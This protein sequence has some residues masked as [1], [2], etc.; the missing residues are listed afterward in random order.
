[1]SEQLPAPEVVYDPTDPMNRKEQM[2]PRLDPSMVRRIAA[3][4]QE[5][6]VPAGTVLFERGQ[7]GIDFFLVLD[8][9]VEI[10]DVDKY[11]QSN[12]FT[13][14]SSRQFSGEMNMFN[15]RAVM[16]SA[17]VAMDS[18]ILRVHSDDFRRMVAAEADISEIIMRAFILRRVGLIRAGF[19]GVVLVGPGH[20]A[21]TLRLERFLVRNGYPHRLID[22]ESEPE[23]DGFI[24]CFQLAHEQLP[25]VICP[26]RCFL[27]NPTTAELADELGITET[28]DPDF[29]YDVVVA[30][31]GPA[32]LAAAVYAAS[33]GL[34]TLVVEGVAP[35]GQA[36]TS[37][38]IENY[39]G[40]PTGISG[41]ALAGR[42][43]AQAQK[44]GAR[45]AISRQ[46]SGIDCS[47]QPYRIALDD[48]Q[49]VQARV[50]IVA[51]GA[52]YR[53]LDVPGYA[54]FEGAGIHYACTA[55]EGQLCKG[56]EV[57][58][59]GGG[60]SAGQAAVFLSRIASHVHVLVRSSGLAATMS[61]YLVQRILRS[62]SIS[63]HTHSEIVGLEGEGRLGQV[64][65]QQRDTG[66]LTTRHVNNVFVMIGAEP[67]TDWLKDCLALD[68]K[69]FVLTGRCTQGHL[70]ESPYA[71][72]KPGIFAV[73][74]VRSGSVK[75]VAS[76]VGEGSV[77]VQ[78]VH[79]YLVPT[80]V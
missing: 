70:L 53:K 47:V 10:F 57:V 16:A 46:A 38:R 56:G 15:R 64:T 54:Q 32:G 30:G 28:I 45:L 9:I 39:L 43:Q 33:E 71:T 55:M 7:R 80:P 79:H 17:R 67:N 35:G 73:G 14:Y 1:M 63:L 27:Q 2:F 20:S 22:T 6:H 41:Q 72:T 50:V 18:H 66:E 36:G 31:A 60:N 42:A 19:G 11:G 58:V 13:M 4:G 61:D 25:V 48:G 37:S 24:E 78:A 62:S 3:Y 74:D 52:R 12:V 40:F 76:S 69:G 44:F 65:W 77:V 59:V 75:R 21:D 5:E 26:E 29:V 34:S 68:D 23:A 8:G 49:S 51:T